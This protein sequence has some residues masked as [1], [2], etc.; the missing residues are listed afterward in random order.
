MEKKRITQELLDQA[1]A[2]G[3]SQPMKK[4][5]EVEKLSDADM[6]NVAGGYFEDKFERGAFGQYVYCPQCYASDQRDF[7]VD[8]NDFITGTVYH[9]KRCGCQFSVNNNGDIINLSAYIAQTQ[10][11]LWRGL[12]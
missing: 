5:E 7:N 6:S 9:C 3:F 12:V 8:V 11:E 10:S 2:A 1:K 4:R